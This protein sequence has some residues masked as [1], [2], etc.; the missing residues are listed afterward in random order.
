M[1]SSCEGTHLHASK[2]HSPVERAGQRR[3]TSE[4]VEAS[5]T[6]C[7]SQLPLLHCL[8]LT[9]WVT[10]RIGTSAKNGLF[11]PSVRAGVS[12]NEAGGDCGWMT[13]GPFSTLPCLSSL[14]SAL[15]RHHFHLQSLFSCEMAETQESTYV[16]AQ[17]T[18]SF[19][20]GRRS[21]THRRAHALSAQ[22]IAPLGAKAPVPGVLLAE[23]GDTWLEL[24]DEAGHI[25]NYGSRL[26]SDEGGAA[27]SAVAGAAAALKRS[28]TVGCPVPHHPQ[29]RPM[30]NFMSSCQTSRE[31]GKRF[32]YVKVTKTRSTVMMKASSVLRSWRQGTSLCQACRLS[33]I[34]T[35][36]DRLCRSPPSYQAID[37]VC[38]DLRTTWMAEK[39]SKHSLPMCAAFR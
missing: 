10:Q 16:C 24:R 8:F 7:G 15:C 4:N 2:L 20:T 33:P 29:L 9:F 6:T 35:E 38:Q 36:G 21:G 3:Q 26:M 18:R 39:K 32:S 19:A 30:E 31:D 25:H 1:L 13:L 27:A 22:I 17:C 12:W 34:R 28:E 37:G 5:T 11:P 14:Q 23:V